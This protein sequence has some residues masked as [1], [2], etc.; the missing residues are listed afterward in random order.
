MTD[1]EEIRAALR[2]VAETLSQ[3]RDSGTLATAN[4]QDTISQINDA[5]THLLDSRNH[6]TRQIES[7]KVLAKQIEAIAERSLNADLVDSLNKIYI[8]TKDVT[9][10]RDRIQFQINNLQKISAVIRMQLQPLIETPTKVLLTEVDQIL[11]Q[12]ALGL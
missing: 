2:I 1:A 6:A 4:V 7:L 10:Y 3:A 5:V 8:A 12:Y 9:E 11:E